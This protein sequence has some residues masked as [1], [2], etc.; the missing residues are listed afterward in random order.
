MRLIL[1]AGECVD[2]VVPGKILFLLT[3]VPCF[4]LL[5]HFILV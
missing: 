5:L 3:L 1:V 2:S 4:P